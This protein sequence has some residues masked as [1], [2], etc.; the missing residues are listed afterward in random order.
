MKRIAKLAL[1]LLVTYLSIIS[2]KR[3]GRETFSIR[4]SPPDHRF[5]NSGDPRGVLAFA[6]KEIDMRKSWVIVR[7]RNPGK[8]KLG[9]MQNC[10]PPFLLTSD[11]SLQSVSSENITI[12]IDT[13]FWTNAR[14]VREAILDGLPKSRHYSGYVFTLSEN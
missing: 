4:C 1:L 6:L 7:W 11:I 10:L 2:M 8:D 13:P 9:F 12:S 5:E 3:M 14:D